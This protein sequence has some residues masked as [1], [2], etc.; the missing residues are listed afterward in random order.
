MATSSTEVPLV[1][2]HSGCPEGYGC[3]VLG[4]WVGA[5]R[6]NDVLLEAQGKWADSQ[7]ESLG[8]GYRLALVLPPN[9]CSVCSALM[10]SEQV[11]CSWKMW[12]FSSDSSFLIHTQ[13]NGLGS[14]PRAWEAGCPMVLGTLLEPGRQDAQDMVAFK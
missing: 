10:F 5:W 7:N 4:G 2:M 11:I 3:L 8:G 6:A 12:K 13:N 9:A 14:T 1:C